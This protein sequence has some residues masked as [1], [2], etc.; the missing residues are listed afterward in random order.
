[1]ILYYSVWGQRG[2]G[3]PSDLQNQ[4]G[5]LGASRVGSIPTCPRQ[6]YKTKRGNR[7]NPDLATKNVNYEKT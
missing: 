6:Y 3:V 5:G 7:I 4:H 2:A 1:M